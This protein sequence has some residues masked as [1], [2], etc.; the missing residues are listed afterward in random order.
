M[1]WRVVVRFAQEIGVPV[2]MCTNSGEKCG[3]NV[4]MVIR[5]VG[6]AAEAKDPSKNVLT[7]RRTSPGIF[8]GS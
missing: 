6:G 7:I 2:P 8:R 3:E 1:E 5:S 4:P